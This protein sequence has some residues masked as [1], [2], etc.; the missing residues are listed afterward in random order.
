MRIK[1]IF[2]IW[3]GL[4]AVLLIYTGLVSG[5]ERDIFVGDLIVLEISADNYTYTELENVFSEFEIVN[6][7][8]L[9]TGYEVTLRTFEAGE[10]SILLGDK[11]LL[12]VVSSTLE[13]IDSDGIFPGE[14]EPLESYYSKLQI[15]V[16]LIFVILFILILFYCSW[17]FIKNRMNK[18]ESPFQSFLRKV[19]NVETCTG[20]FF[21]ELTFVFK[22]Y[23]E[24]TFDCLI[25]GKTTEEIISEIRDIERLKVKLPGIREWLEYADYYK[26]TGTEASSETKEKQKVKLKQLVNGIEELIQVKEG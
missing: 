21:V 25:R 4:I 23:L 3:I 11:E 19:D 2:K 24:K 9:E 8:E 1:R 13:E 6:C 20:D 5:E 22:E 18:W 7:S 17:F 12:I 26:Y 15:Y 10:Y 14:P 16:F